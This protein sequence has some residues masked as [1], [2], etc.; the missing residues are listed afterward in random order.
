M[1][2]AGNDHFDIDEKVSSSIRLNLEGGEGDDIY[3]V[4]GKIKYKI[5]DSDSI[6]N[7]VLA[8]K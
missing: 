3:I 7:S 4:K 1:A 2:L 8:Q 6:V 5:G